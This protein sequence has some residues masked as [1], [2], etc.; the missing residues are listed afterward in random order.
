MLRTN[1]SHTAVFSYGEPRLYAFSSYKAIAIA[2]RWPRRVTT[3]AI[4]PVLTVTIRCS[5][6]PI[7][8]YIVVYRGKRLTNY[9]VDD[10]RLEL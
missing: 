8:L 2:I 1:R 5:L 10:A 3:A 6:Y 7:A 9:T 4:N